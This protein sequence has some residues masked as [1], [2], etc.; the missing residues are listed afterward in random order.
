VGEVFKYSKNDTKVNEFGERKRHLTKILNK[1]IWQ[2]G[3][4]G[5]LGYWFGGN[6][7]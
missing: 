3:K 6:K 4:S 7:S 5:R 1:I 2:E